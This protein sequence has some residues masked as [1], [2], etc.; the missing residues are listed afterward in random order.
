M[1]TPMTRAIEDF[2]GRAGMAGNPRAEAE[3]ETQTGQAQARAEGSHPGAHKGRLRLGS[4]SGL[5]QG[6]GG[7]QA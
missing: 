2:A 4:M 5:R 3:A 1:P 6:R 7:R